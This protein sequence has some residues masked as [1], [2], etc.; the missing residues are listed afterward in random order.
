MI[1]VSDVLDEE[2]KADGQF[3]QL[4]EEAIRVE[5]AAEDSNR[6]RQ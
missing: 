4:S 5:E 2:P 6:R 3:A 1:S